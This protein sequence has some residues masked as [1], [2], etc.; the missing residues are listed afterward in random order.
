MLIKY[1]WIQLKIIS[2]LNYECLRMPSWM[3]KKIS[4]IN[5]IR[6]THLK[7]TCYL[8]EIISEFIWKHEVIRNSKKDPSSETSLI[9]RLIIDF[10]IVYTIFSLI[11]YTIIVSLISYSII[12]SKANIKNKTQLKINSSSKFK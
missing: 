8:T 1:K 2:I 5:E 3:W 11:R 12:A 4:R 10:V 7:E 6:W 9:E